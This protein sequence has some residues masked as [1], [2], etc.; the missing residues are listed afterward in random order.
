MADQ[1]FSPTPLQKLIVILL[2][3]LQ[4]ELGAIELA[5]M[6]YLIDVERTRLLGA[7]FTGEVYTRQ[8]KGP[9]P[10][11]FY[12]A[13]REMQGLEV[14]VTI[15][16]SLGNSAY[17]K[18]CHSIGDTVRFDLALSPA[19]ELIVTRIVQRLRGRTPRELERMAY[20]TEP[21]RR[22]L[23]EEASSGTKHV[24]RKVDLADVTRDPKM[25]AWRANKAAEEID[26]E[27]KAFLREEREEAQ[28]ILSH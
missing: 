15:K 4:R 6:L 26:A 8:A 14:R 10:L 7:S 2:Q 24:G 19:D 20:E 5:K 23:Q 3:R 21:M 16:P 22:I 12:D 18:H 27:Y 25:A 1:D 28:R 17:D 9:L 11:S 13:V